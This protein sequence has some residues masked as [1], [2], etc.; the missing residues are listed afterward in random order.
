M[1]LWAGSHLRRTHMGPRV[2]PA[3]QNP[4][5]HEPLGLGAWSPVNWAPLCFFSAPTLV[6]PF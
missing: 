1:G 5:N 3:A 2:A 4:N 6:L